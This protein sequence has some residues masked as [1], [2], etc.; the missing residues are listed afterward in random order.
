[1]KIFPRP[2]PRSFVA[3]APSDPERTSSLDSAQRESNPHFRHGKAAGCR[4]IMGANVVCRIVK[5]H[6]GAPDQRCASAPDSNP[7][8]RITSAV[9]WP[10]ARPVL[11]RPQV[12]P[13][14]L[15][16][17]PGGLRVRCAATS[18]LIP[19]FCMFTCAESARR[20]SNPRLYPYKRYA[21]TTELR[22]SGAEG[23]RTLTSRLKRPVC[24][25]YTT[26]PECRSRVLVSVACASSLCSLFAVVALRVE[27]SATRLSAEFGRPALDYRRRRIF[28]TQLKHGF[29]AHFLRSGSGVA[30][31]PRLPVFSRALRHLSYRPKTPTKKA[32]CPCDTGLSVFC[33]MYS[34]ASHA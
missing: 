4:Y 22:A 32:R 16:P 21:L 17:S 15:E 31:N 23:T 27:L 11:F 19:L 6:S 2:A 12:G 33:G 10:H 26:T 9:S 20:E 8:R 18:T 28:S 30:K 1:M 14:G 13:E 3:R 34:P 25:R 29:C 7:R 5:E 24:S